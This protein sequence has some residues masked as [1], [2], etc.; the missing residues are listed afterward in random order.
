MGEHVLVVDDDASIRSLVAEILALEDYD[1]ETAANG[2]Q[3]LAAIERTPP[4]VML[5]DM[6]MPVLDGWGVARALRD[7]HRRVPTVV[8]TAA[9]HA[10]QWCAEVE[11]DACLSKPFDIDDLL[12]TV[13]ELVG[14]HQ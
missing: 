2:A 1:V 5:L 4:E 3:A 10:A 11:A 12:S 6:R 7:Q 8:M 13:S 9:E 14:H